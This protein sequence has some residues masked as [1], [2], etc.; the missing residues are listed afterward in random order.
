M[1]FLIVTILS[2]FLLAC[3]SP[4]NNVLK[5]TAIGFADGETFLWQEVDMNNQPQVLDT[6]IVESGSFTIDLNTVQDKNLRL[7]TSSSTK[8]NLLVFVEGSPLKATVYKDSIWASKVTGSRSNDLYNEYMGQL[9][10]LSIAKRDNATAY[11]QARLEQDGVM[12]NILQQQNKELQTT[13][14]GFK[15]QFI[16]SNPNSLFTIMVLSGLL[17][18]KDISLTEAKRVIAATDK[19][20]MQTNLG[21]VLT[22]SLAATKNTD[23]GGQAPEFAAPT[24]NGQELSLS[25]AMGTYTLIDFWA[26]WCK[27]CRIENPNLVRAYD[28]YHDRGFNIIGVSL[29]QPKGKARWIKAIADDGLTWPQISNL[30]FWQDPI[31]RQYNV[32]AIPAS[33]LIDQDGIIIA[34]NLR[35][36]KLDETLASLFSE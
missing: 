20:L 33:F 9:R 18:T 35:G 8:G 19:Q 25:D 32:K 27:P 16:A 2:V 3:S 4:E 23:I 22:A 1:R 5:G 6:V 15:K 12:I 31:A 10:D 28:Q 11:N 21:K 14:R 24:P 7:L 30:K 34:K 29:D 26:S 13:E 17:D 36:Q